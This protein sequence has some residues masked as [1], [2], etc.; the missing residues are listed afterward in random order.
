M[1]KD[2]TT[3]QGICFWDGLVT[4]R[5]GTVGI[6]EEIT[7][8]ITATVRSDAIGKP[9]DRAWIFGYE[10]DPSGFNDEKDATVTVQLADLDLSSGEAPNPVAADRDLQFDFGVYNRGPSLAVNARLLVDFSVP[11]TLTGSIVPCTSSAT[12]IVCSLGNIRRGTIRSGSFSVRAG[13]P[14]EVV[15]T[16][17]AV[18]DV[19]DPDAADARDVYV[20]RIAPAGCTI[21]GTDNNDTL[22]GTNAVNTICG[23]KGN[24]T[25]DPRDGNDIVI[26]ADGDDHILASAGNDTL[27]G[28]AG[29]DTIEAGAGDDTLY[30]ERGVDY[31]DGG[32]GNDLCDVG[33][34]G[35]TTFSCEGT[36]PPPPRYF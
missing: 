25:I 8:T 14:G 30:G 7:V 11:V 29:A 35:G 10:R 24:D 6:S 9:V 4:C 20:I 12:S 32:D 3:D 34:D 26:A 13:A 15:A 17:T 33:P 31:L 16:L 28:G 23:L 18:S 27:Y 22:H 21:I 36:P 5:L 19:E 2:Q 1:L